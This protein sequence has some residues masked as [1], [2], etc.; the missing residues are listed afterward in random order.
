MNRKRFASGL[1][2][3][4]IVTSVLCTLLAWGIP[5]IQA[6]T[7]FLIVSIAAMVAFC[8][9]LYTLAARAAR[10]KRGQIFIQVVMVAVFIK[11][12]LCLVLIVGYKKL[13]QPADSS[14]L[15][16]FLVIY[17]AF[18]IFEVIFMD[19][20]GRYTPTPVK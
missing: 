15:W 18:T 19:R 7:P 17:V 11:M 8:I 5:Q 12:V 14:F 1:A 4:L 3:T 6:H 9:S 16:P 10:Q 2:V 20:L 13:I